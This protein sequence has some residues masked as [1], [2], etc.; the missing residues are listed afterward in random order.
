MTPSAILPCFGP[1][2][3]AILGCWAWCF[4]SV[5]KE[6]QKELFFFRKHLIH[7]EDPSPPAAPAAADDDDDGGGGD[8]DDD[9][10]DDDEN[11]GVDFQWHI[12]SFC[13]MAYAGK[14]GDCNDADQF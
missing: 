8:D 9:D 10:D 1:R 13:T 5:S 7:D 11:V 4:G 14:R 2:L 12:S 3:S 6:S